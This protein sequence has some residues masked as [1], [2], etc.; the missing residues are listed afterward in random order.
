MNETPYAPEKLPAVIRRYLETHRDGDRGSLTAVF[1]PEAKVTD[2]NIEYAGIDAIRDWLTNAASEY[3]YTTD[4]TQQ[5]EHSPDRWTV[6][7]H[8]EGNFPG[9][10]ADLRFQFQLE[11]DQVKELLIEP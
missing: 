6:K 11:G 3:T 10:E 4:Y 7:A 2:E 9:G 5:T 1:T 8:L